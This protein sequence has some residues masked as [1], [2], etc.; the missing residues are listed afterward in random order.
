MVG[1]EVQV[2]RS[3]D[4]DFSITQVTPITSSHRPHSDV[5]HMQKENRQ[6]VW[7][8]FFSKGLGLLFIP[9]LPA[10]RTVVY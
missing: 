5:R 6:C 4:E 7:E 9:K 2:G 8:A 10:K 3:Q 1:T